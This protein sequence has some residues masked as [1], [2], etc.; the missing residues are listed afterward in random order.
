MTYSMDQLHKH[1]CQLPGKKNIII[2]IKKNRN[3]AEKN[4]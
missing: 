2:K 4:N 3:E 1:T